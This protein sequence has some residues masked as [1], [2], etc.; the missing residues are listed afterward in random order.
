MI[1]SYDGMTFFSVIAHLFLRI[2]SIFLGQPL[3]SD[4]IQFAVLGLVAVTS[5]IVGT[6][7]VL[8]RCTMMANAL[9]HTLL[10][11]IVVVFVVS[12]VGL[13]SSSHEFDGLIMTQVQLGV[14]AVIGA[15]ITAWMVHVFAAS[16]SM[17]EDAGIG[18]A[19][20]F[21]FALGVMLLSIISRNAHIGVELL[22]GNADALVASDILPAFYSALLAFTAL[23]IFFRGWVVSSFDLVFA[24][25]AGFSGSKYRSMLLLIQAFCV[26]VAFKSVGVV[27]VL[28]LLS[29]PPLTAR[30]YCSRFSHMLIIST[31]ISVCTTTFSVALSRHLLTVYDIALSTGAL[32]VVMLGV[33]YGI[34]C[35]AKWR[36][37]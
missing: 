23:I 32:T 8:R 24:N 35:F 37:S 29:I 16:S 34:F 30:L 3:E 2:P 13:S 36:V 18:A 9:S 17:Q 12:I 14:A 21:L 5:S 33:V 1:P 11:G 25:L 26:V 6:L 22:I 4:E 15:I 19:F 28:G 31:L 20:T 10:I 27:M 7:S